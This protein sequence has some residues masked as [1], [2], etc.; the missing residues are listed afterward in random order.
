M[1]ETPDWQWVDGS[2][3]EAELGAELEPWLD[4]GALTAAVAVERLGPVG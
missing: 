3:S 2:P 1:V 4:L